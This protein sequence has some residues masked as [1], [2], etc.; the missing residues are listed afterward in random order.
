M[1][2]NLSG[3]HTLD[4]FLAMS[5]ELEGNYELVS[6]EIYAMSPPPSIRHQRLSGRIFRQIG[7][8]IDQN[9]GDCEVFAAPTGVKLDEKTWVEPDIFVIC[10]PSKIGERM[11]NGAP[12]WVIEILSPSSIHHDHDIKMNLYKNSGVRE[13]W[14]VDPENESVFVYLFKDRKISS[15][16]TYSFGENMIVEIYSDRDEPL[17]IVV[18]AT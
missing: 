5:E 13:Y 18:P 6:G 8:Y 10:D 11:C 16:N 14:I 3:K 1:A 17:K 15:T 2:V 4:E 7:Q 9:G 12:D